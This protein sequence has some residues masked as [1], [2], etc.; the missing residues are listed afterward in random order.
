MFTTELAVAA[1]RT[2][3][4]SGPTL[5]LSIGEI[6]RPAASATIASTATLNAMRWNGRCCAAWMVPV[7]TSSS[8]APADH[9]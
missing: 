9:P 6:K 4:M 5:S 3:A 1:I 8:S 2:R 7:A